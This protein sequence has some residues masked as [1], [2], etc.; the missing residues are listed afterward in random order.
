MEIQVTSVKVLG[1]GGGGVGG[2]A[3]NV[4]PMGLIVYS[5]IQQ[6]FKGRW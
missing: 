1:G 5:K 3:C 4:W 2:E 6:S